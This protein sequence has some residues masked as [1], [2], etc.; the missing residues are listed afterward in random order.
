RRALLGPGDEGEPTGARPLGV[1][2]ADELRPDAARGAD[3]ARIAVGPRV[4][5]YEDRRGIEAFRRTGRALVR[6]ARRGPSLASRAF[7]RGCIGVRGIGP[8]PPPTATRLAVE[9]TDVLRSAIP[10][11]SLRPRLRRLS[12]DRIRPRGCGRSSESS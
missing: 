8:S 5:F 3:E 2:A 7:V 12:T 1:P 9:S 11:R 10:A 6:A 4:D